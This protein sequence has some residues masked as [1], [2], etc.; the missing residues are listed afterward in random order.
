[1]GTRSTWCFQSIDRLYFI[2][3]LG[4]GLES[5]KENRKRAGFLPLSESSEKSLVKTRETEFPAGAM[6]VCLL[7]V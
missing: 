2:V 7:P 6:F 5:L 4:L 3:S 1:M